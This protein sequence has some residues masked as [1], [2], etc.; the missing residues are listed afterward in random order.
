MIQLVEHLFKRYINFAKELTLVLVDG[1][2][3]YE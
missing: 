2:G 3:A 1:D